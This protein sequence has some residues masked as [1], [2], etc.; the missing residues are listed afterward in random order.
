VKRRK[1]EEW[2]R[3]RMRKGRENGRERDEARKRQRE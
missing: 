3:D 1:R 2:E